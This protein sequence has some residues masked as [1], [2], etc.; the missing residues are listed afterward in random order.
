MFDT[1]NSK[2]KQNTLN[3][4]LSKSHVNNFIWSVKPDHMK[5]Y[6]RSYETLHHNVGPWTY[7]CK[8]NLLKLLS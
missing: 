2:S 1:V 7:V 5:P 8:T 3:L 6:T 4:N